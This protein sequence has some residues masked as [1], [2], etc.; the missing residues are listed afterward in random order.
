MMCGRVGWCETNN[1]VKVDRDDRRVN[2]R[3]DNNDDSVLNG[4][5]NVMSSLVN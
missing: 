3:N 5:W 4:N 2:G 1:L